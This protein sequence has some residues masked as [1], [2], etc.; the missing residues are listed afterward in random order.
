MFFALVTLKIILLFYGTAL[1]GDTDDYYR[2]AHSSSLENSWRLDAHLEDG[3]ILVDRWRIIGYPALIAGALFF[4][5][6]DWTWALALFQVIASA[7]A[8]TYFSDFL[9]VTSRSILFT[10][11]CTFSITT[12]VS[13]IWDNFLV[14]DS[15]HASLLIGLYTALAASRLQ[16]KHLIN[17]TGYNIRVI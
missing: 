17:K 16:S 2:F 4:F 9:R 5:G 7:A 15:L 3:E 12:S 8:I 6:A 1:C 14:T 13:F 11:F 10:M